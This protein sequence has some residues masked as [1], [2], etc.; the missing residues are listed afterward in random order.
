MS[1]KDHRGLYYAAMAGYDPGG[2]LVSGKNAG[3]SREA[4][5]APVSIHPSKPGNRIQLLEEQMPHALGLYREAKRA[6]EKDPTHEP[7]TI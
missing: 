2:R 6:R 1:R 3:Q 7:I 5:N 4:E